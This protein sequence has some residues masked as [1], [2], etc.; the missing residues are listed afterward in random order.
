MTALDEMQ[1]ELLPGED[2]SD[3]G[4]AF[5]IGLEESVDEDGFDPGGTDWTIQDS[6]NTVRGITNFGEDTLLGPTWSWTCHTNRRDT[7]GALETLGQSTTAWRSRVV[8]EPGA[9][10]PLRYRM[11]GRT[12][13]VYGRPRKHT[14]SPNNR[15]LDGFIPIVKDFKCVDAFTY[16][17]VPEALTLYPKL[18]PPPTMVF[19]LKFP[20]TA[21]RVETNQET[22]WVGG[23]TITYPTLVIRGPVV[24]PWI[25]TGD[26]RIDLQLSLG[27]DEFVRIDLRPWYLSIMLNDEVSV[28]GALP[29]RI[30]LEDLF[31]APGDNTF[32]FGGTGTVP[33]ARCD[34][35]FRRAWNSL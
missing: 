1:F 33:G 29:R 10:L 21:V 3:Q 26:W 5:G 11:G 20:L 2:T 34:V 16:D 13:R 30:W 17:D 23:D 28:A 4:Y 7:A 15:M 12:R 32:S 22:V 18:A 31:L 19:P 27:E 25:E 8:A 9:I 24:N 14:P 6:E 35:E